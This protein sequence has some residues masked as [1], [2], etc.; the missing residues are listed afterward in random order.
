M[1]DKTHNNL[2]G[3]KT[4]SGIALQCLHTNKTNQFVLKL[5]THKQ[6]DNR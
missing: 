1:Q 2:L 5:T 4:Q 3:Q 6:N